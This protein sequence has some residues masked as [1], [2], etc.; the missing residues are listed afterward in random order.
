M[1]VQKLVGF[2][3]NGLKMK[4]WSA[5]LDFSMKKRKFPAFDVTLEKTNRFTSS[6]EF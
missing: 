1:I 2:L 6:Y 3:Q 5:D 4:D